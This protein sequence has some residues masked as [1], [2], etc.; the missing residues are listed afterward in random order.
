MTAKAQGTWYEYAVDLREYEGQE[1]WVAVRHFGCTDQFMI[2]VDDITLY[3]EW[4]GVTAFVAPTL[5]VFPNPAKDHVT[6][7]S[8]SFV[9]HYEIYNMTGAMLRCH[10]VGATVF[11]VDLRELPTGTYLLKVIS[12]GRVQT[13]RLVKK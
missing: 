10:E 13:K 12:E 6:V 2:V 8:E 1:I 9:D 3:R 5:S 4:D 7:E 11:D